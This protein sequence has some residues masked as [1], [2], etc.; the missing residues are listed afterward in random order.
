MGPALGGLL[1]WELS[2]QFAIVGSFMSAI[3]VIFFPLKPSSPD[4][5]DE[6]KSKSIKNASTTDGSTSTLDNVSP[7][8]PSSTDKIDEIK[9]KSIE[10]ASITDSS[11]STVDKVS[12]IL[13]KTW[14]ILIV[15]LITGFAN[16]MQSTVM[17]LILKRQGMQEQELGFLMSGLRVTNAITNGA[18]LDWVTK[19]MNGVS[20]V[21]SLCLSLPVIVHAA[22]ALTQQQTFLD[23]PIMYVYAG[24]TLF[25]TIFQYILGT[26]LTAESTGRLRKDQRGTELGIEHA[27][28]SGARIFAPTAGSLVLN[29][30]GLAGVCTVCSGVYAV[31]TGTWFLNGSIK[32]EKKKKGQLNYV[33]SLLF[34]WSGEK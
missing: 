25:L 32:K 5:I 4:S 8:K 3:L 27:S 10:N 20:G 13:S 34:S 31:A 23:L 12:L 18:M 22:V 16:S 2:A 21:I 7:L 33:G 1:G 9:S 15:K 24:A 29:K 14:P 30:F 19:L 26:S 17:P 28:F 6:I 11:T